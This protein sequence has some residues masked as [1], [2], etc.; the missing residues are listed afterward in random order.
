MS[1]G[2]RVTAIGIDGPNMPLLEAWIAD[3]RLPNLAAIAREGATAR[4]THPKAFR[5]ERC[6]ETFL[7]GRPSQGCGAVF[8]PGRYAFRNESLQDERPQQPFYAL[9]AGFEVCAFDLPA[10]LSPQARGLQVAGWGSELNSSVPMSMPPGLLAELTARHGGDPKFERSMAVLDQA[11][12]R[13]ER[14]FRLPSLYD[15]EGLC[16]FRDDLLQAIERRT[17]ICEDLMSRGHWDL[18]LALYSESHSA[19]HVLW[20]LGEPF[21]VVPEGAPPG[22]ALLEVCQAI[23]RGIGRIRRRVPADGRLVVWTIDHTLWNTMDVPSLVLLPELLYRWNFPGARALAAAEAG[24]PVPPMRTDYRRH[25]KHEIWSLATA[26]GA[27]ELEPPARQE[28]RGDPLSWHPANWYQPL[29]RRMKAF[30]LP[31]VSDGHVRLN[32]RGREAGGLIEPG[33]F[34]RVL[35]ELATLLRSATDPRTG[36]PLA[37]RVLRTRQAPADEPRVPPDLI[38]SWDEGRPA[39]ALD[40][41]G[42]GRVGPV[43]FFRSGGHVAHGTPIENLLL[44]CGPGIEAG[45]S[46][47]AGVLEDLPATL[48]ALAGAPRPPGMTGRSLFEPGVPAA[49]G[50]GGRPD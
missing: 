48:L 6:W 49:A 43:P 17:A 23:D 20:H 42:F 14:S 3:G 24:G 40:C 4:Y 44:A 27:A 2:T 7:D 33:D 18:F 22:H 11:S 34:D 25:W 32:V 13:R 16:Q 5:N 39:D 36:R 47:R 30:A 26:A 37:A 19:N 1:E 35:D 28:E 41:P 10:P 46:L 8:E 50:A 38:V 21:P 45:S 9:G 12:G 29:W 31:S 15:A